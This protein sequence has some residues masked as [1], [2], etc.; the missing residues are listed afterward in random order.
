MT[1]DIEQ[2]ALEAFI[3]HSSN[4]EAED[5]D[6]HHLWLAAVEWAW[7]EATEKA[8]E[9]AAKKAEDFWNECDGKTIDDLAASIRSLKYTP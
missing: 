5:E 2:R 3:S 1:P 8:L 9:D 6:P 7:T 4:E